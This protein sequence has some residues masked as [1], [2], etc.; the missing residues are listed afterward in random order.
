MSSS[1]CRIGQAYPIG[2]ES[3]SAGCFLNTWCPWNRR[4]V[5]LSGGTLHG[6]M[7]GLSAAGAINIIK[8]KND[9]IQEDNNEIELDFDTLDQ[10]TLWELDAYLRSLPSQQGAAAVAMGPTG[11]QLEQVTFGCPP[12]L[13]P[14]PDTCLTVRRLHYKVHSVRCS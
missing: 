6:D 10:P 2:Y 5:E 7:A 3:S 14:L 11:F 1:A 9:G 13:G 4:G 12:P 8:K